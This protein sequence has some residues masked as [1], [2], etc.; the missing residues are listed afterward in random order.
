MATD[1]EMTP[2]CQLCSCWFV[3]SLDLAR[4]LLN[5]HILVAGKSSFH[6]F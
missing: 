2:A 5:L 4:K 6:I 3:A 1:S